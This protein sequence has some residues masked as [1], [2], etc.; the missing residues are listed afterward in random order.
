MTVRLQLTKVR[1]SWPA[2]FRWWFVTVSGR[3]VDAANIA[4]NMKILHLKV[5]GWSVNLGSGFG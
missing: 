4:V 5:F 1:T 2:W 3:L